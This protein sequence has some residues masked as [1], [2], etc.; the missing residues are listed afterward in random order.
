MDAN[1]AIFLAAVVGA[2]IGAVPAFWTIRQAKKLRE[3]S[4]SEGQRK[5][6]QEKFDLY[7]DKMEEMIKNLDRRVQN[8]ES[9]TLR[10]RG[11]LRHCYNY[12][13][14]LKTTMREHNIQSP[15]TPDALANLQW[16]TLTLD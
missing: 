11:L 16:D 12:I 2:A 6:D 5:L 7:T 3:Q 4:A 1:W 13:L 8:A 14:T 10:T 15:P 9:E